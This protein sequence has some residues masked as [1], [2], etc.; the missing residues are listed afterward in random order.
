MTSIGNPFSD[1]MVSTHIK[2]FLS[3]Q[4]ELQ[5]KRIKRNLD[6]GGVIFVGYA[7]TAKIIH[8]TQVIFCPVITGI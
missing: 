6:L 4:S 3:L 8:F 1:Y 2:E 7:Y 5:I